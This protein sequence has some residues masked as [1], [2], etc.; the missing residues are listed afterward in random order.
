MTAPVVGSYVSS[1]G[2]V[3]AATNVPPAA[4]PE[5]VAPGAIANASRIARAVASR[6]VSAG[7]GRVMVMGAG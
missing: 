5:T 2:P 6:A 3:G 1:T 7:A 4:T